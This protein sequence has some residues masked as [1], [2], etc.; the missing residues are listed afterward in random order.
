M[1]LGG[2]VAADYVFDADVCRGDFALL[3]CAAPVSR[4]TGMGGWRGDVGKGERGCVGRGANG[5]VRKC[6]SSSC[7]MALLCCLAIAWSFCCT[8]RNLD[9]ESLRWTF[10][11]DCS[12]VG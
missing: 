5:V 9:I 2:E 7:A 10:R 8:M 1:E 4:Y 12:G 11:R 3:S 6:T